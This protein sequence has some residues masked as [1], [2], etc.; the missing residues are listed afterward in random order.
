MPSKA[1]AAGKHS[2]VSSSEDRSTRTNLLPA[3]SM[4]WLPYSPINALSEEEAMFE[5]LAVRW[6]FGL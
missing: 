2:K 5:Q 1:P 6:T 4:L 3:S